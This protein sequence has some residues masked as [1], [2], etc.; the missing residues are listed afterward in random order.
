MRGLKA[1]IFDVDGVLS[2]GAMYY[3]EE[4]KMFK[5]FG[6]DDADALGILRKYCDICFISADRR[7][8]SISRK[9]VEEDM[10]Y[11]FHLVSASE[12]SDW[13][14]SRYGY[15]VCYVGDGFYD[16]LV[17]GSISYG[18]APANS[19]PSALAKANYVC[20]RQGGRGAV[21]EACMWIVNKFFMD[22]VSNSERRLVQ[23]FFDAREKVEKVEFN[24]FSN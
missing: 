2:T 7:G 17:F 15:D 1:V 6:P 21:A 9:R 13:V 22:E 12:R 16:H 24:R 18:I 10:G 14:L 8:E 19:W 3:S 5:K 4:G 23:T 11:P 20:R